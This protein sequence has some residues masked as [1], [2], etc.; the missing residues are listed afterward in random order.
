MSQNSRYELSWSIESIQ[1]TT[2]IIEE[3]KIVSHIME[4]ITWFHYAP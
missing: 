1:S 4:T 3:T 2:K